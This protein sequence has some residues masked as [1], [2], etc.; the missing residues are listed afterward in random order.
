MSN[1]AELPKAVQKKMVKC[2]GYAMV[3]PYYMAIMN[4]NI[5]QI[6]SHRNNEPPTETELDA[7]LESVD[8]LRNALF[9]IDI[10]IE[11]IDDRNKE[12]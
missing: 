10:S 12:K 5:K 11:N 8:N 4:S 1:Q 3:L 2:L 6:T 7:F 9:E